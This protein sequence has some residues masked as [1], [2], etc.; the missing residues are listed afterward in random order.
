MSGPNIIA[1]PNDKGGVGK[2]TTAVNLASALSLLGRRVLVVDFDSQANASRL[3]GADIPALAKED[4]TLFAAIANEWPLTKIRVSTNVPGVDLLCADDRMDEYNQSMVGHP[5]Q[6]FLLKILMDC[7]EVK[8]YFAVIVDLGPGKRHVF[9]QSAIVGAH[10]Y[11]VPLFPEKDPVDGLANV[12][13]AVQ[14]MKKRHNPTLTFLGCLVTNI[15]KQMATHEVYERKLR[16][17]AKEAN[18]HVFKTTIPRSRQVSS[19][20][21]RSMSLHLYRKDSPVAVAYSALAGEM[22]PALRGRRQ[23][24]T[25]KPVDIDALRSAKPAPDIEVQVEL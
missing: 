12:F 21:S 10:Y 5:N 2:T 8:E 24:R 13:A 25:A 17:I 16:E 20:S 15:D 11:I 23:G 18:F 14:A 3:L 9:F 19:A 22:L 4:R 6:F 1:L 7:P